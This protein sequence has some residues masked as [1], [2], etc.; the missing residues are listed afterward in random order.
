V[1]AADNPFRSE[2]L[3]GLQP[4]LHEITWDALVARLASTGRR[5]AL[6]GPQ[7]SGKTTLLAGLGRRL[8]A[9]GYSCLAIRLDTTEPRPGPAA[10]RALAFLDGRAV[11]LLDGAEQLGKLEWWRFLVRVRRAAGV[12]VTTHREGRLPTLLRCRTT[13][14][15][16]GELVAELLPPDWP[17]VP[18]G[19]V[20]EVFA[21]TRGNLR[22]ALGALYDICARCPS[23]AA[24]PW[25][26]G[27]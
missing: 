1:R 14:A 13:V 18:A 12:V 11:V 19:L 7:G 26:L 10:W 3:A 24:A 5:G 6:V 25:A 9:E 8:E 27:D 21:A 15:L 2:R 17:A 23:P 22:E 20:R 16:L 4:R